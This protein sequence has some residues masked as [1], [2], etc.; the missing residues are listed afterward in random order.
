MMRRILLARYILLCLTGFLALLLLLSDS[1]GYFLRTSNQRIIFQVFYAV[2]TIELLFHVGPLIHR[3]LRGRVRAAGA[4]LAS[5]ALIMFLTADFLHLFGRDYLR[6]RGYRIGFDRMTDGE[7]L[8]DFTI[9]NSYVPDERFLEEVRAIVPES[10]GILYFGPL[11]GDPFNYGLQPRRVYMLPEMQRATLEMIAEGWGD[12]E[13][14]LF[15]DGFHTLR[16]DSGGDGGDLAGDIRQLA[17]ERDIQWAITWDPSRP[18]G[19]RLW[20]IA[21]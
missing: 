8:R 3:S 4:I 21:P 15:P 5:I 17:G 7:I 20:R 16:R 12:V 1:I 14:P 10:D 11:R 6:M 2:V 13:D 18:D 9:H 19:G